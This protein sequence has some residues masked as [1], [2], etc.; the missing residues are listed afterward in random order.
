[1]VRVSYVRKFILL[2]P[3]HKLLKKEVPFRWGGDQQKAFQKVSDVLNSPL[4]MISPVKG[5]PIILYL[6]FTKQVYW[7]FGS[8]GG[9]R[10]RAPGML[11][12]Q[13]PSSY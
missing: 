7:C 3:F 13:V 11:F 10:G 2:E 5:L 1:M 9:R 8:I 12:D 6:T 4:S